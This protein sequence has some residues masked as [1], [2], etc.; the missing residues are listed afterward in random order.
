[1]CEYCGQ[2]GNKCDVIGV[3]DSDEFIAKM[4]LHVLCPM[5]DGKSLLKMAGW[6]NPKPCPICK[7]VG[8]MHKFD[9]P[10][11]EKMVEMVLEITPVQD[12]EKVFDKVAEQY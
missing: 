9:V 3:Y 12:R 1:M 11:R 6:K 8:Q 4:P 10:T 5:C 2:D 7:G